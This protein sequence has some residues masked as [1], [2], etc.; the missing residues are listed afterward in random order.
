MADHD[1]ATREQHAACF[2]GC[3]LAI[4]P[5]PALSG[6][7][8]VCTRCRQTRRLGRRSS[9]VD[10]SPSRQIKPACL[11]EQLGRRVDPDHATAAVGEPARER[12]SPGADIDDLLAR[13]PDAEI[14]EPHKQLGRKACAMARVVIRCPTEIDA[15]TADKLR[16][17]RDS[18][19]RLTASCGRPASAIRYPAGSTSTSPVRANSMRVPR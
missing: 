1:R 8:H 18:R 5:V 10:V 16:L 17:A 15:H 3:S 12:S 13:H 6:T 9:V 4:E 19:F 7:D 2:A 11:I 14:A